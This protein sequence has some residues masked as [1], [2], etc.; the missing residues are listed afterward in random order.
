VAKKNKKQLDQTSS[1]PSLED[2]VNSNKKLLW[3][4]LFVCLSTS[5]Y[6]ANPLLNNGIGLNNSFTSIL[7]PSFF[8]LALFAALGLFIGCISFERSTIEAQTFYEKFKVNTIKNTTLRFRCFFREDENGSIWEV[9]NISQFDWEK[10]VLLIE[11]KED[12][13]IVGT[14]KY[15]LHDIK[16]KGKIAIH[17]NFTVSPSSKWRVMILTKEG[18]HIIF[19]GFIKPFDV[20]KAKKFIV[21]V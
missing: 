10:A 6:I 12:Q 3:I 4:G 9:T 18:Y 2:T 21:D 8:F 13:A 11:Q 1:I 20:L 15:N 16:K 19:P 14:E 7:P 5:F 17:S